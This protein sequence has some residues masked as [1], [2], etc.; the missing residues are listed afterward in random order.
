MRLTRKQIKNIIREETVNFLN[1]G[2]LKRHQILENRF[3]QQWEELKMATLEELDTQ[4]EEALSILADA[5]STAGWWLND[6][7]D[8]IHFV[9]E[10]LEETPDIALDWREVFRQIDAE[11]IA[12]AESQREDEATNPW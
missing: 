5:V 10:V 12:A 1:E 3:A 2:R 7:Q 9:Q 4:P 11:A 8:Q 6:E